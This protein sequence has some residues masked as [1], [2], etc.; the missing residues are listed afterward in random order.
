MSHPNSS[1]KHTFFFPLC[2]IRSHLFSV[3]LTTVSFCTVRSILRSFYFCNRSVLCLRLVSSLRIIPTI[4]FRYLIFKRFYCPSVSRS[5]CP[6]YKL[7]YIKRTTDCS[8]MRKENRN[9]DNL[10]CSA[11]RI[12]LRFISFMPNGSGGE[13]G[14]KL[15]LIKLWSCCWVRAADNPRSFHLRSW[16][17]KCWGSYHAALLRSVIPTCLRNLLLPSSNREQKSSQA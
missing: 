6:I 5:S 12:L 16:L 2:I 8:T 9:A 15:I 17:T 3:L 10:G 7:L 1:Y 4:N 11:W 14:G 13:V